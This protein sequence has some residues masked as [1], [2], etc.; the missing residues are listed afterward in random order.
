MSVADGFI[1][2][3]PEREVSTG[4]H[5]AS[6][7]IWSFAFLWMSSRSR[8]RRLEVPEGVPAA[9]AAAQPAAAGRESHPG[10]VPG[11]LVPG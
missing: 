7:T 5:W 8:A 11:D 1:S 6:M 10:G 3:V 2:V 9:A 4:C